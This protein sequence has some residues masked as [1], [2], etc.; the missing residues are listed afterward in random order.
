MFA[1]ICVVLPYLHQCSQYISVTL[2]FLPHYRTGERKIGHDITDWLKQKSGHIPPGRS[3]WWKQMKR[4]QWGKERGTRGLT[5]DARRRCN[6]QEI[7]EW[8]TR[9][10]DKWNEHV[11]RMAP[12]RI[13][14]DVR[15]KSST[16]RRSL[17]RPHKRWSYSH[18]GKKKN[19]LL[20]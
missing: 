11:S 8:I 14:R 12:E 7:G 20:V 5:Q 18:S 2:W 4:E 13:V 19:R 3:K 10:R 16:S 1:A 15:D 6:V 17:G 9:R